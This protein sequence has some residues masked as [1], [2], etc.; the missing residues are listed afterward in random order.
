MGECVNMEMTGVQIIMFGLY[1]IIL[2]ITGAGVGYF[3]ARRNQ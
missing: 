2:F 3:L 1:N